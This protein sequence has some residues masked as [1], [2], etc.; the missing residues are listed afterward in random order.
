MKRVLKII[1]ITLLSLL[2]III[3]ASMLTGIKPLSLGLHNPVYQ[4]G[5][6]A[7]KGYDAVSYFKGN[8]VKGSETL[9][10]EWKKSKWLFSSEA[11]MLEFKSSPDKYVPQ[12]GGYCAFAVSTGFSAP[13]DPAI[14]IINDAKLYFFSDEKVKKNFI[15]DPQTTIG[16]CK[17]HWKD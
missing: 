14:W 17:K 16:S 4:S 1:G 3:T 12:F 5:G 9:S 11:N 13:A 2:V 15:K 10:Y 6:F 7:I 8:P